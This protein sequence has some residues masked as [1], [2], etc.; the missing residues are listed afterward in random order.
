RRFQRAGVRGARNDVEVELEIEADPNLRGLRSFGGA[1]LFFVARLL[2]A[3]RVGVAL[4]V[5]LARVAFVLLLLAALVAVGVAVLAL[6]LFVLGALLAVFEA[7]DVRIVFLAAGEIR[8]SVG[9]AVLRAAATAGLRRGL[10]RKVRR[11]IGVGLDV[12]LER[13]V[14]ITARRDVVAVRVLTDDVV[15]E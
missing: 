5:G 8:R 10:A 14:A 15:L 4:A 7:R 3:A 9:R 11:R 13:V 12:D 2:L 6:A 1:D